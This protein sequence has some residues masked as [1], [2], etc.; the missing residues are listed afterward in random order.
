MMNKSQLEAFAQEMT[1]ASALN[2]VF[3]EKAG[4]EIQMFDAPLLA[5]HRRMTSC[6]NATKRKMPSVR[7]TV[8]P[9]NGWRRPKQ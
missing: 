8:R 3:L 4:Q 7:I 9:E 2:R 5:T 6:L 1:A